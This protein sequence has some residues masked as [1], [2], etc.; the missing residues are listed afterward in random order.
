[1]EK[2]QVERIILFVITCYSIVM[3]VAS[4]I[5]KWSNFV[6]PI[7]CI[8]L[9]ATWIIY[10][11]RCWDY[12]FRMN[13][14]TLIAI[15]EFSLY[16][17]R[18]DSLYYV[19]TPLAAFSVLMGI[20][21]LPELFML[22]NLDALFLCIFHIAARKTVPFQTSTDICRAI[23]IIST[24]GIVELVLFLRMK[25]QKKMVEQMQEIIDDLKEAENSKSDFL[26]NVSH[27]IR[28]P[29]NTVCG[30]S[31]LLLQQ[32]LPSDV[33]ES[34]LN[35]KFA[36]ENLHR[37]VSDILDFTELQSGNIGITEEPYHLSDTLQDMQEMV[38]AQIASK[39]I[40]FVLE[41]D[42]EIPG[43]LLGDEQ[44]IRR[45]LF[46]LLGNAV[47]FTA[48]G[49]IC[50][51]VSFR[52]E[53]YGVNLKFTI[54]DTGKGIREENLEKLFTNYNQVDTKKNRQE[55]GIGLGLAISKA[56]VT[57]MGGF[58]QVESEWKKG[59]TIQFVIPQKV[60][61]AKPMS[62]V[63]KERFT[64]PD[65]TILVVDDNRMNLKVTSGLL[66][67]YQVRV[68]T[69]NSGSEAL[70]K[71]EDQNYDFVLLDHMMPEMDGVE[72]LQKIRQKS[73]SYYQSVPI[74]A[75]TANVVGGAR[76]MLLHEGFQDFISK[77]MET[78]QL[79]RILQKYIPENKKKYHSNEDHM[80][81]DNETTINIQYKQNAKP[82]A[83]LIEMETGV[84][85]CGGSMEDYQEIVQMYCQDETDKM[86]IIQTCYEQKDWKNYATYVHALKSTSLEIGAVLLSEQAKELELA[87]KAG[88]EE[89]IQERHQ[90][91]V[92]LFEHTVKELEDRV[93]RANMGRAEV[94]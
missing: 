9:L 17:V 2:R 85:Y 57:R 50:M 52:E 58:I 76:E 37:I 41:C 21:A 14:I 60:L 46:N 73:G 13:V 90:Q 78:S 63:K 6:T 29:I 25:E 54:Q 23:L 12:R 67:P 7:L 53:S 39:K 69:A 32:Q 74:I 26:A 81:E 75:F 33:K 55:G 35:I 22:V 8:G 5:L 30:M 16:A 42:P 48:E 19:L 47:K 66:K 61:D 80:E 68:V 15:F 18:S 1:M 36:G 93:C 70:H 51:K 83:I 77:P 88:N 43:S 92:E 44:K 49:R 45:F 3:M 27:E 56:L 10:L 71:L 28:T 59:T 87:A 4:T 20:T 38:V 91:M 79:E 62:E 82:Q 24:F 94:K 34:V 65:A 86:K 11:T 72:T 84:R 31:K 40:E 64:A 89:M